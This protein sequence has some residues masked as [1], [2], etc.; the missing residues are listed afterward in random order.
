MLNSQLNLN[1][2]QIFSG[3][4]LFYQPEQQMAVDYYH[5]YENALLNI[6]KDYWWGCSESVQEVVTKQES[7]EY[8]DK[9]DTSSTKMEAKSTQGS[10]EPA[11][12]RKRKT[13]IPD[14]T[15]N[16]KTILKKANNNWNIS[17]KAQVKS[18]RGLHNG[19]S[20]RRSQ[21]IGVL[22]NGRRWQVLINIGKKKKY[23]GTYEC[24]KTAALVHDFYSIG[25][26][27]MNAKTNFTYEQSLV[28]DMIE[29]Y[30][31]EEGVF[32][33]SVFIPLVI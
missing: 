20:Q 33:P 23:I 29:S 7:I 12:K 1:L 24:E 5:L 10:L 21:Y 19:E 16:L 3:N 25:L 22:R 4:D 9:N 32:T 26:N 11:R 13:N 27:L 2:N 8:D 6:C 15:Q 14:L 30:L 28:V 17:F 18:S 31:K